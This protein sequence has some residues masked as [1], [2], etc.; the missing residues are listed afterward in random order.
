VPYTLYNYSSSQ[1]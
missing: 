1:A